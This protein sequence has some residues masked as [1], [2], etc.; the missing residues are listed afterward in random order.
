[1][2]RGGCLQEDKGKVKRRMDL[3]ANKFQL[4]LIST[5]RQGSDNTTA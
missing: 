2:V 4:T 5:S 3:L 1:M